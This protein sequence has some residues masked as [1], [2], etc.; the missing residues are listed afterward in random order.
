MSATDI[1]LAIEEQQ[2]RQ[3]EKAKKAAARRA[4]SSKQE[5]KG[6]THILRYL[7]NVTV[8]YRNK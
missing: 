5:N 4:E 2:K 6:Q 8:R 3:D 1:E 7:K